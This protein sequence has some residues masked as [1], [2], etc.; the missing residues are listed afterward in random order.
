[1]GQQKLLV[2]SLA[3]LVFLDYLATVVCLATVARL[4][5]L[6][7]LVNL[8]FLAF[9][10]IV[11]SPGTQAL[12]YLATLDSLDSLVYQDLFTSVQHLPHPQ[13]QA[14]CGGMMCM[15]S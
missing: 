2:L 10:D 3:H 15:V 7:T 5:F 12:V 11:V 13:A 4:V 8:V 14:Q 9:L 1:M 6:G